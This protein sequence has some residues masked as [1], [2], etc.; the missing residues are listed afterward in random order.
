MEKI[1][2]DFTTEKGMPIGFYALSEV[3]EDINRMNLDCLK[4]YG[5][6]LGCIVVNKTS[7]IEIDNFEIDLTNNNPGRNITFYV[8]KENEKRL[9]MPAAIPN[10]LLIMICIL[11]Q[12]F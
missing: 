3:I 1:G 11:M 7:H 8:I 4:Y 10:P 12:I 6:V 2:Y 9:Y 5:D